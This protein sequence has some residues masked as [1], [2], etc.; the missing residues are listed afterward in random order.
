[1]GFAGLEVFTNKAS[2]KTKRQRLNTGSK[3]RN[4]T[5]RRR[6]KQSVCLCAAMLFVATA[7][8]AQ[9]AP[10]RYVFSVDGATLEQALDE[11]YA[12]TGVQ[13]LYSHDLADLT[14]IHSVSGQY[15]I[16]EAL[17]IMLQGTEFSG[18]L[19]ESGV[20]VISR[21]K[22]VKSH[23]REGI[24]VV[25]KKMKTS[26]LASVAA[27][28]VGGGA[29]SA[30][31]QE[32][33][34]IIRS[35]A[36]VSNIPE[37]AR[38][39]DEVIVTGSRIKRAGNANSAVPLQVFTAADLDEMGTTDLAEALLQLPGVSSGVSP[40]NSNNFIQTSGLSTISLRRLG[41]SRTLVLINGKRVVSNSGNSDRVSLS[42]LPAGFV[43]R[44]EI[45]TG[46]ASA[47][48]GSDAIAGV[49]N[50][51]LED[52]KQGFQV[53]ARYSTPE[54][55][56]GEEVRLNLSYGTDF[57]DDRGY[58]FIA[59]SYRDEA[60]IRADSTRPKS[61][62]AIEFDDPDTS[63]DDAF[64]DEINAPGCDPANEDRHCFLGSL[65]SST[66]GG[67]FEGDAWFVNG[68][69]FND[70][71]LTAPGH[72]PTDDFYT[73][74]DG[75]NF[76]PGRSLLGSREVFNLGLHTKYEFTPSVEGSFV[77][78]YSDIESIT[79]GGFETLNNGD[80]F[81]VIGQNRT[82]IGNMSSSHPFIPPE[83]EATRSGSVSFG[84]RLVELGE[85]KRINNRETIRF[86]G[87]LSGEFG[88]SFDWEIFGTY[89]KFTQVQDNPN[90]FN[91]QKA[92][93]ALRIESDGAGSFQCID[94]AAR[95]DGC[96]PLNIFG[97]GTIT[98]AAANYIRYNGHAEQSRTQFT[99][100][101]FMSGDAFDLPTGP[102]KTA[103]GVEFRREEQDTIGDPDGDLIGG[104]DGDPTTPD[105]DVTTLATFPTL[106]ASYEV[107]EGYVE[108]DIPLKE[109]VFNVQAAARIGHY[110]TIGT[111][112]SYNL[113][114]VWSPFD[115]VKFRAQI[116]RAQRA[117]NITEIFS[118][119]R[120]DSD[121]LSD[122]CE[123]IR[124][125]GTGIDAP[126]GD[127]GAN[128]DLSVVAQNCLSEIGIQTYLADPINGGEFDAP[129]SVFGPNS[130][131]LN[132]KEETADTIT[133]GAIFQPTWIDNLTVIVD[134]YKI[135]ISDAITSVSTQNTVDLCYSSIDFDTNR[136]CSVITRNAVDGFVDQ[137][138]NFQEN[139]NNEL[140]EG[141]DA[142]LKY[143]FDISSLPG[144]WDIDLRYSHYFKDQVSFVGLG[145]TVLTTSNLGEINNAKDEL[146]AKL[147]YSYNN[148]RLTYTM[149]YEQ[150]GIDDL[151]NNADPSDDRY[152]K[153][154][155][156]TFHR[157]YGSYTFGDDDQYRIYGGVN[158]IFDNIGPLMPTG[159]DH[160]GSHNITTDLNDPVGREFYVGVRAR[161]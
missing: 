156:E 34:E 67:V 108:I 84:R 88:D 134:Y 43:E 140:V 89:G 41:D 71:G 96:V 9:E 161:F 101:A 103:F 97:E 150:G 135:D 24:V 132:V 128:A 95:A 157:V 78:L 141:L 42:T 7:G 70:K 92:R 4:V 33:P 26:L 12:Q 120:P 112:Y 106:S 118:P 81:G 136:F 125:D 11:V 76:R 129:G 21:K 127:G 93:Y 35:A 154:S 90:E 80:E 91:A 105:A 114:A 51:L 83:V 45:T 18:G 20:I 14:G 3:M 149:Q 39:P 58:M 111:I 130:G 102:V 8:Y 75:Y 126:E 110:N 16:E 147:G 109:D 79:A 72:G 27:L 31:A 158:N 146:R 87:D 117:P 113:G 22:S 98:E 32:A 60:M 153:A 138:I 107:V 63:S 64:A 122:P 54:A 148:I 123:G 57:A 115:G 69:W 46:G 159:L 65:S 15:T 139:L 74:A 68:Q 40:K 19:T 52:D 121:S 29:N 30:L 116:S 152:F 86:M 94:T 50:F 137:V 66:P 2:V 77:A 6:I 144:A 145:G 17:E 38:E 155:D 131:N 53:D 62:L 56:G 44:T 13:L 48:Y 61:I 142:S 5:G 99:A 59:G 151:L 143:K 23:K 10:Q 28:S 25:P 36:Q 1:M 73:D 160:G 82:S 37:P 47:V 49:A 124:L 104:I 119:P 100:G 85:Q 55:S 133:I